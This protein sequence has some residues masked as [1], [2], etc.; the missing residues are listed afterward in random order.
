MADGTK[1]IW[2]GDKRGTG[3]THRSDRA[4]GL[5]GSRA[6]GI[7]FACACGGAEESGLNKDMQGMQQN[8]Y[9]FKQREAGA[10]LLYGYRKEKSKLGYEER[11]HHRM[12]KE[13]IAN[14]LR[15]M[16]K[17]GKEVEVGR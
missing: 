1:Q 10:R 14:G 2:R 15:M 17:M 13:P 8:N 7:R 3:E 16:G 9:I 5:L 4:I 11:F 6:V 12:R